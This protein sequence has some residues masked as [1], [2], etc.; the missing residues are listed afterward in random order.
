[1]Q[2]ISPA[3]PPFLDELRR[4]RLQLLES[5]RA[6]ELA[7]AAPAP[8]REARWAE[9]VHVALVELAADFG[10]HI[11]VTEGPLGFYGELLSTAPRLAGRVARL[12]RAHAQIRQRVNEILSNAGAPDV[13]EHV[14]EVRER[15]T[16][17][18]A[19][20]HRHRQ[21]GSDLIYEAYEADIGGE[22]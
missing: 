11:A 3:E 10:E 15:A 18:L 6:V 14:D 13:A 22:T 21:Q 17:L 9:R 2:P 5:M 4:R 7:L 20:L 19:Q 16:A 1:M 12:T 8:G